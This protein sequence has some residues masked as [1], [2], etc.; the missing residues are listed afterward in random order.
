MDAARVYEEMVQVI[1][2]WGRMG[3]SG[4]PLSLLRNIESIL[5]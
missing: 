5:K 1:G 3:I 4:V 2:N